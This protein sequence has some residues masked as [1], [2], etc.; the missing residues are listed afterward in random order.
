MFKL[1][2]KKKPHSHMSSPGCFFY[3]FSAFKFH[4]FLSGFCAHH[5]HLH[6]SMGDFIRFLSTFFSFSWRKKHKK[7]KIR[8]LISWWRRRVFLF[9]SLLFFLSLSFL[10]CLVVSWPF[11]LYS[12]SSMAESVNQLSMH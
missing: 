10:F 3:F 2:V 12:P 9:F 5:A 8:F 11:F 4:H 1:A 6:A 7:E